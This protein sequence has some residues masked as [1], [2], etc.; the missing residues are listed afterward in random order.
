MLLLSNAWRTLWCLGS[1][2]GQ[3]HAALTTS[4]QI[5]CPFVKGRTLCPSETIHPP[6][7]PMYVAANGRAALIAES[8]RAQTSFLL[9]PVLPPVQSL[10]P[11]FLQAKEAKAWRHLYFS[12]ACVLPDSL[13]AQSL[14]IDRLP[15]LFPNHFG[16]DMPSSSSG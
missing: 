6:T 11:C 14:P 16:V 9:S 10:S 4:P 12:V 3:L 5:L 8:F 15:C 7:P 13:S 1:N 2:Q